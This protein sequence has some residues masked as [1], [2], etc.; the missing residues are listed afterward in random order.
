MQESG[1]WPSSC[2]G[3]EVHGRRILPDGGVST[4]TLYAYIKE[5]SSTAEGIQEIR[6][7]PLGTQEVGHRSDRDPRHG[8]RRTLAVS[9]REITGSERATKLLPL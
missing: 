5:A 3:E 4:P 9:G 8:R 6:S 2:T 1:P 7:Q